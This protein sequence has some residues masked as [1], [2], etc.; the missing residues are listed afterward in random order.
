M[1]S[2]L[3][4][5]PKRPARAIDPARVR[6]ELASFISARSPGYAPADLH[7]GIQIFSDGILDSLAF[8]EL[9]SFIETT[10]HLRLAPVIE[11]RPAALDRFGDLIEAVVRASKIATR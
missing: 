4:R 9:V 6:D 7:D 3:R 1:F 5:N 8:L 2:W 11:V 10:Y